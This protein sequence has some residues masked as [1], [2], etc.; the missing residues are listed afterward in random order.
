[1]Q[2]EPICLLDTHVD[3][4]REIYNWADGQDERSIFWLNSL[5]GIGKSTIARTVARHYFDKGHLGAS[6]FFLQGRGDVSHASKF[7]TSI[8]MQLAIS[9]PALYQYVS[10]TIIKHSDIASRSLL[11]Q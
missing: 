1:M 3:L 11:D 5:A 4:L 7:A 9:I 10:D 2:H 8:A 6:F